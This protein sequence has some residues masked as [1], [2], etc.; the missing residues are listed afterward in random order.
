MIL[1]SP[2]SVVVRRLENVDETHPRQKSRPVSSEWD[3]SLGF[4]FM[5]QLAYLQQEKRQAADPHPVSIYPD[6]GR[7]YVG[8]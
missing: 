1:E 7:H 5:K 4:N 3:Y 6:P 2:T 8:R